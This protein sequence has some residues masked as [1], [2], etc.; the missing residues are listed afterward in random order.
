MSEREYPE[1]EPGGKL[2]LNIMHF[3]RALRAAGVPV[4]P[5]KVLDAIAAIEAVG[6]RKRADFYAALRATLCERR[7]HYE[8]F[9]QAFKLFWR[10]PRV[11]ERLLSLLFSKGRQIP[12][13]GG[14][15]S[16][17]VTDALSSPAQREEREEPKIEIEFDS[18][19]TYSQQEV[20]QGARLRI[21]VG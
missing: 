20:L 3:A 12:L 6:V 18:T 21:D 10:D 17:R 15:S 16:R 19:L 9:D 1:V 11:V 13:E 4:G 14:S 8:V 2:G 5:G 7:E